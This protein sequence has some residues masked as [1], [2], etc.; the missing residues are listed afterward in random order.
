MVALPNEILWIIMLLI[1][2]ITITVLYRLLGREGLF[3]WIPIAVILANIQVIK[4]VEIFGLT[5]TLGNIVYASSFLATDILS[6]NHGK[7]VARRAVWIGFFAIIIM[8]LLMNLSLYFAPH[9]SDFSQP[10]LQAIFSLMPRIALAS[11]MAYII[12]Q[13]HDVWAY[14]FWKEK[15]PSDRMIW[16]RN[17]ASTLV[18]QLIDSLVFVLV[19]FWGIYESSVLFQILVTTYLM[20]LIVAV[21]DTPFMYLAKRIYQ[22]HL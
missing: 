9:D 4:N 8:T 7:E 10:H 5:A 2:F 15:F 22:K 12:S 18:S 6:E 11:L 3:V 16:L 20:K 19:A 14:S 21:L 17:N 1:N 13:I